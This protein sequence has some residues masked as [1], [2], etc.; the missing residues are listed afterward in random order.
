MICN[1]ICNPVKYAK[2]KQYILEEFTSRRDYIQ[3]KNMHHFHT[4]GTQVEI[5]AFTQ[6]S[7]YDIYVYTQLGEWAL[8]NSEHNAQTEK[9]FYLNNECGVHFNPV[10]NGNVI[11]Q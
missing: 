5:F 11:T 4:W 6:L 10:L 7:R 3:H 8:F 1:Y 9:A 2:L